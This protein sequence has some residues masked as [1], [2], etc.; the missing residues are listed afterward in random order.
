M[1][2]LAA[3]LTA[4]IANASTLTVNAGGDLQAALNAAQPGDTILLQTGAT[5]T[6]TFVLPVKNDTTDITIR[7]PAPDVPFPAAGLPIFP[8]NASYLAN[9]R[10]MSNGAA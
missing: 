7:S 6:G 4:G 10:P 3:A 5:F 1:V 2:C 8:E 9:I